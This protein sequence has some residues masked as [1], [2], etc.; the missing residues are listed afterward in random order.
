MSFKK[1]YYS[2]GKGLSDFGGL[3]SSAVLICISFIAYRNSGVKLKQNK[4]GSC[5]ILGNGP[6]LKEVLENN[7]DEL[8]KHDI[9]VV[10]GFA[11]GDYFFALRPK[12]YVIVDP[13]AF[14]EP[15]SD[16]FVQFQG[17]II[18][19][20]TAMD[21]DMCFYAPV[22]Q[23]K[24]YFIKKIESLGNNHIKIVFINTIPVEG[25]KWFRNAICKTGWAMPKTWNILNA[26]ICLALNQG[27]KKIAIYG[28]DHSW[29]KDIF[30]N[31]N[32]QLCNWN[33]HFHGKDD[34]FVM[35]KGSLE[36]GLLS[37]AMCLKSYRYLNDY[38]ES[39]GATIV[40]RTKGS[41]LDVFDFEI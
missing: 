1:I 34:Y 3:I 41:Y 11:T 40:N 8:K 18:K 10:N 24:S 12:Y 13:N 38:A 37:F 28:A 26:V 39:I 30:I 25:P 27:Y 36:E 5:C 14:L 7:I 16:Y 17:D 9:F 21:W 33:S 4:I 35:E 32:N 6:S 23:K 15:F 2:I 22:Q 19:A 20:F 29:I 31:E